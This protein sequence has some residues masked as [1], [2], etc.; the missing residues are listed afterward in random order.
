MKYSRN[1]LVRGVAVTAALALLLAACGS[2]SKKS[3]GTGSPTT[4]AAKAGGS[5]V[6]GAEQFPDCINPIT[7]CAN[8]SWLQWLFPIHVLPRLMELDAKNNFVPSPL[9]AGDPAV[10]AGP[11]MTVTYK[12]NPAAKWEP[13]GTPI[14]SADVKF[15]LQAYLDTKGSLSTAGYDQVK[16]VGTPDAQTVVIT[17]KKPYADWQDVGGGF[18]GVVLEKAKFPGGTDVSKAMQKSIDF[19]GGPWTLQSF[20]KTQEILVPNKSYWQADRVPHLDKVTFIPLTETAQEVQNLKTGQVAAIYPQP[21][22]DNV[23]AL[24]GQPGLKNT[25]GVTTQYE[26]IWFNEKPGKPFADKNLR[27][28]F[29]FAFDRTK[30]LN[31]IVKPFDPTVQG[32]NCAAWLPTVGNWCTNTDFADITA[33]PAKV[34]SSM[35]AAGYAKDSSGIW[36]E[37]GKQL[38][39]HW[40]ENTGNARREATQKEFIPLLKQQGFNIVTDNSSA[41]T[42]FQQRLP[43]GDYDFS[44]FIQVTS[45]DP[46]VTS[47]LSS[48]QIPSAANKGAGQNDWWYSNTAADALMTKSDAELD[49]TTR[50]GEIHDLDKI[51]RTDYLLLPLYAFPA[52]VSWRPDQIAGPVDEFIN[53]PE[54]VFW[55]MYAWSKK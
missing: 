10:S 13:D 34:A 38:T 51:L 41:D 17:F 25:F 45:P 40:M 30:F 6:F 11:P 24:V 12:L 43:A 32:L 21:V 23:K 44:M 52:M 18:S 35:A 47:I 31:D 16:S 14:T 28:A 2:S 55:N 53:N 15:T 39:L 26:N 27:Q 29:S 50:E 3:N 46:T 42:M 1:A 5:V 7:Q 8:S 4:V 49:K 37:G 54:S 36:A 22:V 19:T 48:G 9:L 20:S 33:D